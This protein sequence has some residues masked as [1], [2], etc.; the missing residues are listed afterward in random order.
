[1]AS[2]IVLQTL[3]GFSDSET[4]DA[5]TFDLRWKAAIGWPVTEKSFH[6]TSLTY[7]RRR[8]AASDRPNR[9]F[10]VVQ[11]VIAET[12]AIKGKTRRA[13]DSTILDDAVATQD[14]VTQLIAAIRRVRREVPDA[15]QIVARV[16]SAHDYDDPMKPRIAWNDQDARNALIDAL[17]K[18]ALAV[19]A[20]LPE[21]EPGSKAADA[22]GILALVAGQ[23]VELVDPQDPSD[24]PQWRIARKVAPDRLISTVD[25][26]ARHA[27]KSVHR[28][29]DGFK[30]HIAIEP[31]TG[32]VTACQLTKASGASSSDATVGIDLLTDEPTPVTVLGDSAYA[33]GEALATLDETGH[34]PMVKPK[35]IQPTVPGGF[36]IDDFTVD[37]SAGTATCP[38]GVTRTIPPGRFVT[39]GA[40]CNGC[41]LRHRCTTARDGRVLKVSE[42]DALQRQHRQRAQDPAWQDDY[43]QHRPMVER[44]IAWLTANGNRKVRYRGI[45]KNDAWL[46]HRLAALNLRRLLNLGLDQHDGAWSLA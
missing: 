17:V 46:Q 25:P 42:H 31:E 4:T 38:A 35:P 9:I 5:V 34:H 36:S 15:A 21:Q 14:T 39:F 37:E 13:L 11:Q 24:P 20:A 12:G 44:S 45:P 40:A 6:D 16:T 30:A 10:E 8:L 28:R 22:V 2:V 27:H 43:R 26:D 23:D 41:P 33:S 1:M 19:L 32:L 18:D 7:W 29:Q 3:N